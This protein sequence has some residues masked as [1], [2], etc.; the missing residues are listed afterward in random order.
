MYRNYI[1]S[2]KLVLFF[3][4]ILIFPFLGGVAKLNIE[5]LWL[6]LSRFAKL[7][8]ESTAYLERDRVMGWGRGE[9][10]QRGFLWL[11]KQSTIVFILPGVR[12][13][14]SCTAQGELSLLRGLWGEIV[15]SLGFVLFIWRC[16]KNKDTPIGLNRLEVRSWRGLLEICIQLI[17][18]S[19][20]LDKSSS[21]CPT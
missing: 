12:G 17:V 20:A 13:R 16:S 6:P 9:H 15:L 3:P 21:Q 8:Q 14:S 18:Q 4:I 1:L 7:H 5:W 10:S 19:A 2:K 11:W